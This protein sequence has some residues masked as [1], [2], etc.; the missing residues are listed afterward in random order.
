MAKKQLNI[1]VEPDLK[2]KFYKAVMKKY[3]NIH[4][5][6]SFAAKQALE[7][8]IAKQDNHQNC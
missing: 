3:G 5:A 7:E 2:E 6:K 8:W 4:G 1:M